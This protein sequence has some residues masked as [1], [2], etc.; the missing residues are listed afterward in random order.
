MGIMR[1][2]SAIQVKWVSK[3]LPKLKDEVDVDA[4][5]GM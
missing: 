1:M 2:V 3:L 5:N 4:L